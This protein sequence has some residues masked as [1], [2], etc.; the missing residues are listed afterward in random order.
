VSTVEMGTCIDSE[1]LDL[2]NP[3]VAIVA[4]DARANERVQMNL[5]RLDLTRMYM[6]NVLFLTQQQGKGVVPEF[7]T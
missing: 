4:Q 2:M 6:I 7:M 1:I 5:R 3:Q